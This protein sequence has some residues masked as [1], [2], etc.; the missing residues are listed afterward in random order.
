MYTH[1][2][3]C[4]QTKRQRSVSYDRYELPVASHIANCN[5]LPLKPAFILHCITLRNEPAE[6]LFILL[7]PLQQ[8]LYNRTLTFSRECRSWRSSSKQRHVECYSR[9]PKWRIMKACFP[10]HLAG[11]KA[12]Q[13]FSNILNSCLQ[14]LC[15]FDWS[16]PEPWLRILQRY[17]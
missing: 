14:T 16:Q 6:V 11:R 9:L 4:A 7:S 8:P 2:I 5:F 10:R 17:L 12:V 15:A 13:E 3:S 1:Y